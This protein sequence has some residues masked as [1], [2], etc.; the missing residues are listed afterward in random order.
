MPPSSDILL[1]TCH[2]TVLF[3]QNGFLVHGPLLT[4]TPNMRF[5]RDGDELKTPFL[6]ARPG[7]TIRR[8]D[9]EDAYYIECALGCLCA[10]V[11]GQTLWQGHLATWERFRPITLD[12]A[13]AR[14]DELSQVDPALYFR[15]YHE[16]RIPSIIHQTGNSVDVPDAAR[17]NAT[18]LRAMNPNWEYR[19]YNDERVV[20]FIRREF[21][22]EIL[23]CYFSINPRY[24]ATR[25]DLFRYL[26]VYHYGG[27]YLDMKSGSEEPLDSIVGH[28]DEYLL[29]YWQTAIGAHSDELPFSSRGEFQQWHVIATPGHPFLQS[30]IKTVLINI[31][32]YTQ[33]RFG[34]GK[35]AGVKMTGPVAYTKAIFP[36]LNQHKHRF[37]E[38][39]R[40][41]LIYES[42]PRHDRV[43]RHYSKQD[44]PAVL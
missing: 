29:S 21:G 6:S 34:V 31:R 14:K 22:F 28:D 7:V 11:D 12:E 9:G 43:G 44:T 37:F 17:I 18:V 24:G 19:Y 36:L 5:T 15:R 30:V 8:I 33:E 40:E 3:E 42:A 35:S 25:A 1:L 4:F 41:G 16:K 20:D 13:L 38:A 23:K 10:N 32:T 39:Q 26:C 2:D 27:V